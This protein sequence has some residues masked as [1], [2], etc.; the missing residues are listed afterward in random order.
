MRNFSHIDSSTPRRALA[1]ALA[2][3]AIAALAGCGETENPGPVSPDGDGPLEG[4][5]HVQNFDLP[6]GRDR[7]VTGTLKIF[8]DDRISIRGTLRIR[9]GATVTL[10]AEDSIWI[11]GTIKPDTA[12][13]FARLAALDAGAHAASATANFLIAS[14]AIA[15]TGDISLPPDT[16]FLASGI[17]MLF[18]ESPRITVAGKIETKSLGAATARLD[19]GRSGAIEIGSDRAVRA[20]GDQAPGTPTT[21]AATFFIVRVSDTLRTGDGGR[22][23]DDKTGTLVAGNARA[24]TASDGGA[25]GDI[26]IEATGEIDASLGRLVAG[27]GGAG[28]SAGDSLA[29]RGEDGGAPGEPGQ[30]IRAESGHGGE[31]GSIDLEAATVSASPVA[32]PGRGGVAGGVFVSA[33]NGG[34]GGGG[35]DVTILLGAPGSAGTGG[36]AA[37]PIP[38][39]TRVQL[40]DGGNGGD[41]ADSLRFGGAGG[42]VQIKSRDNR[43]A[44]LHRLRIENYGNAG[45]GF[46]GCASNPPRGGTGGGD[47]G[48]VPAQDGFVAV[49]A[50]TSVT[51]FGNTEFTD[52]FRGGDGGRGTTPGARGTGGFS[53]MNRLLGRIGADGITGETCAAPAAS[54]RR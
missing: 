30:N 2:A 14:N 26:V 54:R 41:S 15:I 31:G 1:L 50:D 9:P 47:A 40:R 25:A 8:A 35:G 43:R 12:T 46:D 32:V 4:D 49:F 5:I 23:G 48:T 22:G 10:V 21:M 34:P 39:E 3:A 51:V 27:N 44:F 38:P 45:A 6:E 36:G 18:R 19:G 37:P 16:D 33:G 7:A 24:F 20:A 42:Y 53:L 13:A 17:R 28:G 29:A 11:G 52:S